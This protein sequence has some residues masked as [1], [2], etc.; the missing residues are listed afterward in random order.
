M[1]PYKPLKSRTVK[2]GPSRL[3]SFRFGPPQELFE[4]LILFSVSSEAFPHF[5]PDDLIILGGSRS[6]NGLAEE[7]LFSHVD[8]S[9]EDTELLFSLIYKSEHV[10]ALFPFGTRLLFVSTRFLRA[11]GPGIAVIIDKDPTCAAA[12]ASSEL[13]DTVEGLTFRPVLRPSLAPRTE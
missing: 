2:I 10:A 4:S 12:L 1:T 8:L 11:G 7:R 3:R 13:A 9:E 5:S 6:V